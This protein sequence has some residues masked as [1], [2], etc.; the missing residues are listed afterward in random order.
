M[1]SVPFV[2]YLLYLIIP[3]LSIVNA[4]VMYKI[5]PEEGDDE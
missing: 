1:N 5:V 2:V 3:V 4:V